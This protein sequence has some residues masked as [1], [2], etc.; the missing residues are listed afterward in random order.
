MPRSSAMVSRRLTVLLSVGVVLMC[1]PS[2]VGAQSARFEVASVK[3]NTSGNPDVTQWT[4]VNGR[5][6]AVNV[7]LQMLLLTAYGQPQPLPEYLI[8]GGPAWVHSARFDVMGTAEGG[9]SLA[10]LLR[11]LV[12]DRFRVRAHFQQRERSIYTL[13]LARQDGRLGPNIRVN[14]SDCDAIAAGRGGGLPCV[15]QIRPFLVTGVGF[16]MERIASALSRVVSSVGMPVVDKTGLAGRFDFSLSWTPVEAAPTLPIDPNGPSFF[17]AL[18][19]QLG[20]KLEPGRAP[21]G[22][23]T[24]ESAETPTDN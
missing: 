5:F 9:T 16:T 8:E 18:Q 19:E 12:E 17:T 10:P 14:S 21:V 13:I 20:L 15:G 2:A 11:Q 7:T 22:V 6:V 4:F 3:R 23:L 1:G 24:I